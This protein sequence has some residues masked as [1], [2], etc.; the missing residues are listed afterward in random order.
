MYCQKPPIY[1]YYLV[2]MHSKI[3]GNNVLKNHMC[4]FL[5]NK[6]LCIIMIN[7]SLSIKCIYSNFTN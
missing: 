3:T 1:C 7:I 4:V 2:R 6:K 5:L